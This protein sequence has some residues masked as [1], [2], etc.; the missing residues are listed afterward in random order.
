[1][2]NVAA[3]RLSP[4][5][6]SGPAGRDG[7]AALQEVYARLLEEVPEFGNPGMLV[8]IPSVRAAIVDSY[9]NVLRKQDDLRTKAS[10]GRMQALNAALDLFG[11]GGLGSFAGAFTGG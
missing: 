11:L 7:M 9:K 8:N 10:R 4:D 6:L 5:T 1:M 2:I 3:N